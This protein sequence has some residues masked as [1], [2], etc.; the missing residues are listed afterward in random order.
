[1]PSVSFSISFTRQANGELMK[2][3]LTEDEWYPVYGLT[4]EDRPYLTQSVVDVPPELLKE[5]LEA[6]EWFE[7]VQEKLSKLPTTV[8]KPTERVW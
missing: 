7:A 1:M 5:W 8:I 6:T 4:E 2:M 3:Y